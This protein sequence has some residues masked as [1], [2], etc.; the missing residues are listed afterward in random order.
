M[1]PGL[2]F[3]EDKDNFMHVIM[4]LLYL[5]QRGRPDIRTVVSFLCG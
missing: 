4:Q 2:L 1:N 3:G 5:S